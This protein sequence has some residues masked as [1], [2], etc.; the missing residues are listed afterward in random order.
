[1]EQRA[2][3]SGGGAGNKRDTDKPYAGGTAVKTAA[4]NNKRAAAAAP[5]NVTR[6]TVFKTSLLEVKKRY[7]W[8]D[9]ETEH[10][11][12][13][14][15]DMGMTNM[16]DSKRYDD[17]VPLLTLCSSSLTRFVQRVKNECRS[18]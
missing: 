11:I 10:F 6:K 7:I 15:I 8:S 17:I 14:I 18:R 16:L 12:R 9:R 4:G 3:N 5:P 1:M 13:L 2:A